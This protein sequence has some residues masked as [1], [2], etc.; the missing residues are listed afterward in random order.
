M[1]NV[2]FGSIT[3]TTSAT[4]IVAP[5]GIRKGLIIANDSTS[6]IYIGP[7]NT[8]TTSNGIPLQSGATFTNA[9]FDEHWAGSIWGI[10]ASGTA[11]AR[12]M[13]WGG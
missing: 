12:F 6:K 13:Q 8:V 10:V 11:D 3:V 9:G 2:T 4:E 5:T 7:D 1:A